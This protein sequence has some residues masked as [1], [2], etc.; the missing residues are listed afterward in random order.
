MATIQWA[1][2]ISD[3]RTAIQANGN[4]E[5]GARVQLDI[6]DVSAED[7]VAALVAARGHELVI[8][9]EVKD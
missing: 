2:A 3:T 1:G 6:P 8:T 9:I 5:G 7:V 4:I